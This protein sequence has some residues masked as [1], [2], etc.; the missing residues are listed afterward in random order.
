MPVNK[1]GAA[2]AGLI[3]WLIQRLTAVYMA[4][5]IVLVALLAGGR[6]HG[7]A[8]WSAWFDS[9]L[10]RWGWMLFYIAAL[11]HSWIGL[12]SIFLDYV[13]PFWLRLGLTLVAAILLTI[14]AMW[15]IDIL[16]LRHGGVV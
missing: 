13:K 16:Y 12:R 14:H 10:V 6:L 1:T 4:A 3:E 8:Q 9:S 7:F 11:W 2:H 5:F 15:V